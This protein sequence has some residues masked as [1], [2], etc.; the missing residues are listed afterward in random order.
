MKKAIRIFAFLLAAAMLFSLAACGTEQGENKEQATV[1]DECEVK[2]KVAVL[3]GSTGLAL[4]KFKNDRSYGYDVGY[5]SAPQEIAS[6]VENGEVDIAAVP[7]NIAADLY[8]KTNG[9]IQM[10]AISTLGMLYVL[11]S[12]ESVKSLEDLKGKTVYSSGQG[13]MPEYIVNYILEKNGIE[14]VDIQYKS[15]HD[16][17]ASLA[18]EGKA[19]ICILPGYFAAKV[20]AKN[21]KMKAVIDLTDEWNKV[22]ETELAMECYIARKEFIESNPEILSEFFMFA[23]ISTNYINEITQSLMFLIEGKYFETKE[24]VEQVIAGSNMVFITGERMK[25]IADSDYEV[26]FNANPA[27]IGGEI[28]NDALYHI[29]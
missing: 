15:T 11:S 18:N 21:E 27:S 7:L 3:N 19:E 9:G 6:L 10:I 26:L 23:E 14:D 17:L 22:S 5:Y 20:T 1:S 4:L 8:K 25:N 13:A 2:T 28:P 29:E 16:E 12:D 24:E